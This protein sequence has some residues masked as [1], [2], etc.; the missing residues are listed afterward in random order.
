[1]WCVVP[2]FESPFLHPNRS[3]MQRLASIIVW[4]FA[5]PIPVLTLPADHR[6]LALMGTLC[7]GRNGARENGKASAQFSNS[8][9]HTPPF[10][11]C[12]SHLIHRPHP[13]P[14]HCPTPILPPPVASLALHPLFFVQIWSLRNILV[15]DIVESI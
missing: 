6:K 15:F 1:M 9:L 13:V 10:V 5:L 4:I 11:S 7:T 12:P 3:F 14:I 2:A 8:G